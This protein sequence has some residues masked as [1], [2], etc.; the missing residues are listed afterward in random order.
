MSVFVTEDCVPKGCKCVFS[1]RQR[2]G[3]AACEVSRRDVQRFGVPAV[4]S[5]CVMGEI[6][7]RGINPLWRGGTPLVPDCCAS[8][9]CFQKRRGTCCYFL[10]ETYRVFIVSSRMVTV[11]VLVMPE[12]DMMVM[13]RFPMGNVW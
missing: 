12:P 8:D 10:K 4:S 1:R 3:F 13:S 9:N 6:W 7:M 2:A 11:S 5:S